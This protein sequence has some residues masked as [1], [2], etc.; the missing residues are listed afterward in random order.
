MGEW[1]AGRIFSWACWRYAGLR[2]ARRSAQPRSHLWAFALCV[3]QAR[4][5]LCMAKRQL[6]GADLHH[7]A[8]DQAIASNAHTVDEGAGG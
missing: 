5:L 8:F 3:R 2:P 7:V 1:F 4:E 6:A